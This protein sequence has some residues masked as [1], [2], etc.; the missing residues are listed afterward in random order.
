M[1]FICQARQSRSNPQY[2]RISTAMALFAFMSGIFV[3]AAA[4][5]DWD[6][7]FRD[8]RAKFFVDIFGRN[9]ARLFYCILGI[10]LLALGFMFVPA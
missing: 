6:W 1:Y 5:L 2:R 8:Y 10:V 9:G 4:L 7:F 3:I